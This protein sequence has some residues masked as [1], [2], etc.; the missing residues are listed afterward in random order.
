MGV[1][2]PGALLKKPSK[3][4]RTSDAAAA[5]KAKTRTRVLRN[6]YIAV[7]GR[8]QFRMLHKCVGVR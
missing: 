8:F 4:P 1:P 3:V 2:A 7:V 5:A 6:Q